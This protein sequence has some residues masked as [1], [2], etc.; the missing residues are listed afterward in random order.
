MRMPLRTEQITVGNIYHIYNRGVNK[1]EIFFSDRNYDYFLFKLGAYFRDK[2]TVI[3]YCLMPNHFHILVK[4]D[5]ENFL[6]E[7]LQPFLGAYAKAVNIDQN[8]VGPLFQGRFQA[9]LI[10]DDGHL[11]E[12]VK[13]IHLNPVKAGFVRLPSQWKYSSYRDYVVTNSRSTFIETIIVLDFFESVDEFIRD[14]EFGVEG[15]QSNF[16]SND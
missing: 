12:C 1:A 4:V 5:N 13:Y 7:G 3:A 6:K 11:L 2:A 16:F 15:Y 9:N 8:R 10:T 14:T